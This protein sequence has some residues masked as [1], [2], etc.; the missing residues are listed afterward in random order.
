[1]EF[2]SSNDFNKNENMTLANYFYSGI[3]QLS[4]ID[5]NPSFLQDNSFSKAY[6]CCYEI[7]NKACKPFLQFLL[8]KNTSDVLSFPFVDISIFDNNEDK[9]LSYLEM[10]IY[11][12]F[13]KVC[14]NEKMILDGYYIYENDIY[15]FYN[16]TY[17]QV[18]INDIYRENNAWLCLI[19]EIVNQKNIC[20]MK[21]DDHVTDF[22]ILNNDFMLL[23]D[24]NDKIIESPT[25][26]YVGKEE[27]WINFTFM[28]GESKMEK[29]NVLGPYYYFTN[30]SNAIE[31]LINKNTKNNGKLGLIRFAIFLGDM[32]VIQNFPND[33][34]DNS[35]MKKDKL[36]D[37]VLTKDIFYE[38][39]LMRVTDYDGLWSKYNDSCYLGKIKLD[40]ET[41]IKN[42]PIWVV[43]DYEQQ[44]PLSYHYIDKRYLGDN[45]EDNN[46]CIA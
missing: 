27:K 28:F 18:E 21:I 39:L 44:F 9:L 14:I 40:N 45:K 16:L 11:I 36:Q 42:A 38:T 20:N 2:T 29:N 35:C 34:I 41:F 1:M 46:Y 22:F 23:K 19:D 32:K 13:N 25:A 8:N 4:S 7:N 10:Y 43:K 30:F 6:I 17:C 33:T 5:N 3:P 26:L 24:L 31:Q 37:D 15:F 12:I